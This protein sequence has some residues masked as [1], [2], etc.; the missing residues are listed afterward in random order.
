M[1]FPL[2]IFSQVPRYRF[3]GRRH[4]GFAI[5]LIGILATGGLLATKGLNFGIDFAGGVVM[6]VRT[7]E[8]ADI[9]KMRQL[10]A[11]SVN[12]NNAS[13]Q[14][15]GDDRQVMIRL[16]PQGDEKQ[17]DVAQAVRDVL[18]AEYGAP[19]DYLRVDYVG[20]QVGSELIKGSFMALGFAMLAM[21]FYL[22]F[23]FEWQ[24]GV[25]GI[26]ALLHDAILT[27]GFYS[28]TGLEFNLTSV[29]A[30]LTVIGYSINDSVVIYDRIRE[31]LRRFKV[32]PVG[33]IIDVSV[34][35]TL[36]RTVLTGGTLLAAL[37]GLVWLG[38]DVLF[39]FSAAM[40]F[41]VFVGTYSSIF[42]SSNILYYLN[43]RQEAQD[44]PVE[45]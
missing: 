25:G 21:M 14:A 30:I 44:N 45:A 15:V 16:K 36:E 35:E 33:D 17:G 11:A 24:Y 4:L 12:T 10:L 6:E 7:D 38:G 31:N 9:A 5:T 26:L 32:K 23:R 29:A 37:I 20:P 27:F 39:G 13:L 1:R 3:I 8:A 28:L 34:N 40:I 43:L 22:W 19:I 41:G 42:V 18:D 2:R